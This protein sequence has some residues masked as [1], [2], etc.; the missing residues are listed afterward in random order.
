VV[1]ASA[2]QSR[3]MDIRLARLRAALFVAV[4]FGGA[5]SARAA[6]P[7][8]SIVLPP[9]L[10][11]EA[12]A[13]IAVLDA[14]GR[15]V[16]S[17]DVALSDGHTVKTDATGRARLVVPAG[18]GELQARIQGGSIVATAPVE[19]RPTPPQIQVT[20]FPPVIDT[21]DQFAIFGERF[22][23][24]AD[25]N[26]VSLG[27]NAVLVLAA[28]PAA[29]VLL[30]A[31]E[32]PLGSTQLR[33]EGNGPAPPP[34]DVTVVEI[35]A[36]NP[37]GPLRIGE[38]ATLIV[39]VRGTTQ[40]LEVEL[41]NWSPTVIKMLGPTGGAAEGNST[42]LDPNVRRVRTSGGENNEAR[43]EIVPLAQGKFYIRAHLPRPRT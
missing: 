39:R 8:H 28:S 38:A 36:I 5:V 2:V 42:S 9:L 29:L 6:G 7:P 41:G 3:A 33:I 24:D 12:P 4:C 26:H 37:T 20:D 40:P 1:E 27:S 35:D 31:A 22:Q 14:S 15:L 32:T 17:V 11:A 34:V 16:P 23:G 21:R 25:E 10:V 43:I 18:A 30:P 13:T 19:V